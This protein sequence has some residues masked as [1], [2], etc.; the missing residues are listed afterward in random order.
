MNYDDFMF[1]LMCEED[2]THPRSIDYWFRIIDLDANY[3][4]GPYEMD[5]FY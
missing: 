2:K 3:I 1:F 4:L 5:Y